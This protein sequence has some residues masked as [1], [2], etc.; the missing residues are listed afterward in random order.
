LRHS[1]AC[2]TPRAAF[3][4]EH[5]HN[6]VAAEK[7]QIRRV[8][9]GLGMPQAGREAGFGIQFRLNVDIR[10]MRDAQAA[11]GF[12]GGRQQ[13]GGGGE[14]RDGEEGNGGALV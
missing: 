10:E 9:Q 14:A 4:S 3:A 13:G 2:A 8:R 1:S 7:D 12:G 6:A 5:V 11:G